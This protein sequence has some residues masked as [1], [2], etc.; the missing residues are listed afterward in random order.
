MFDHSPGNGKSVK[1]TGSSSDLI[2][3]QKTFCSGVSQNIGNLCHFHHKGTLAASK[4]IGSSYSGKDPVHDSDICLVCR[5]KASDLSHKDDQGC[6]AHIGGFTC[7]IR[8]CDNGHPLFLIVKI[9][10]IG[11]KHIMLDHLLH[12]R[13]S[14]VFNIQD[15]AFID[16]RAHIVISLG[17]QGQ[18]GKN[19]KGGNCLGSF[20][21]TH[22]LCAYLIAHLAEKLILQS[23]ELILCPQ[24]QILQIL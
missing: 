2:Q 13:M 24:D 4:V 8:T 1:G 20:L 15:T 12:N 23:V 9:S 10:V 7:H 5:N 17:N 3:D 16:L 19:I 21:N 11:N 6:L 14:A 18:R 22:N